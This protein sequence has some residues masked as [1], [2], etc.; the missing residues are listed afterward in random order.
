MSS[1][2]VFALDMA[3]RSKLAAMKNAL[4]ASSM[5]EFVSGEVQRNHQWRHA[6]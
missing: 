3:Q 4:I 6:A 1:D 5:E 2:E